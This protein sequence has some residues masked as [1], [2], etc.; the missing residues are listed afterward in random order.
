ML[1]HCL[2]VMVICSPASLVLAQQVPLCVRHSPPQSGIGLW[3]QLGNRVAGQDRLDHLSGAG[4]GAR[5]ACLS[6]FIET[7]AIA[8][9][10]R[11]ILPVTKV[12]QSVA[13]GDE[14][15]AAHGLHHRLDR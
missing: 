3:G 9:D 6:P 4:Q 7:E 2:L 5:A 1:T 13:V 11:P 12:G 10:R 8:Q 14:V 15:L